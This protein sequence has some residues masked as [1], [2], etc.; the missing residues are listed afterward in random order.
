MASF[1]DN[2]FSS[3][4]GAPAIDAAAQQRAAYGNTLAGIG[5]TLAGGQ[6]GGL[7]ALGS[8]T[9]N[10]TGAIN[11]GVATARDDISRNVNNALGA[12]YGGSG[13]ASDA[14]SRGMTS[15]LGALY[16]GVGTATGAYAPLNQAAMAAYG[17]GNTSST[18]S[19]DALGLNGPEGVARA[20]AAFQTGPGYDFSLNQGLESIAR[21]ANAAGML[22][23]GNQLRESQTYGQGLANQE[24]N[25]WL[26]NVM[27]LG[28]DY[29]SLGLGALGTAAGGISNAALTGG[30]GAA[31]LYSGTAGRLADLISGTGRTAA[32]IYGTGGQSLAD[33]AST[34]GQNL[35]S[36]YTGQS[37]READLYRQMALASGAAQ[38]D[39]GKLGAQ[40]Y[41]DAAAAEMA[42][43][44]NL[45]NLIGSAATG[46][47]GAG[48]I[49]GG[50]YKP[51]G[52]AAPK[53][54]F[55]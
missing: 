35:A 44:K 4:T 17:L 11:T 26:Q 9:T 13:V 33:L 25:N 47:A 41:E 5:Q 8:G 48:Y 21:N 22:A 6:A 20:R 16:S 40:T 19:A 28:K 34:G 54:L 3:F 18:M 55:G 51:F 15:G 7:A 37:G 38:Q 1:F 24:W 31:N 30:T 45:W 14:L 53:S 27:G 29:T 49:P 32:G 50:S 42:G 10:A 43:S 39:Y 2:L 52:S 36:I 46:A 23:S 12:L